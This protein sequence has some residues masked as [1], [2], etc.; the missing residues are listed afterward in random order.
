MKKRKYFRKKVGM[1]FRIPLRENM[2]LV[3]EELSD[4]PN[5]L[6]NEDGIIHLE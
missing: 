3:K 4:L 2:F 5:K 6:V 1:V